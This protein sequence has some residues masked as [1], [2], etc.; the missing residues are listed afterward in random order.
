MLYTLENETL[1][2]LVRSH[3]AELRSIKER[4][5]ETEY[6]WGGDPAWWKYSSPILF[7]IVGKLHGGQYRV[8]GKTYELP[9]HGLGRISDFSLEERHPDSIRFT[10]R[11]SEES[12]ARYPWKFVLHIG[13][14]LHGSAVHVTWEVEN[15]G[16][17]EMPFSIGAHGAYRCPIVRGEEFSD[18]YLAFD[19]AEDAVSL[20][21]NAQGT[22]THRAGF[23][24]E[25]D[26]LPLS[27]EL[28]RDDVLA[29]HGLRS[30]RVTLCSRRSEKSLTVK[31]EGFPWLGIWSPNQGGAPFVCIEPWFGHGD[32]EDY[33]GEFAAREGTQHLAPG[34]T[35]HAAYDIII[36][37]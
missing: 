27:Y 18:A 20:L 3:G 11:W 33:D 1:C 14:A 8:D 36:G 32:Y 35:F 23:H 15:K 9:G 22:F 7:P 24:L 29:S 12:L 26:R 37:E 16:E 10:L 31:T 25:G 21:T 30:R 28:F 19:T 17:T 13:Y 2:V 34:E 4:A 5:D 6:L